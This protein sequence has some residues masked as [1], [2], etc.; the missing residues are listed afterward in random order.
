MCRRSNEVLRWHQLQEIRDIDRKTDISHKSGGAI[1][2]TDFVSAIYDLYGRHK[3]KK[4][5]S[6][7]V[8]PNS[9]CVISSSNR[10]GRTKDILIDIK[11]NVDYSWFI[12]DF[13]EV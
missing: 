9:P 3:G 7:P 10:L 13:A 4:L 8:I 12:D 1:S 11:S 6:P 2:Y 5:V